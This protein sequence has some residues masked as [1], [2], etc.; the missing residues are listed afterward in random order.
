MDRFAIGRGD[1]LGLLAARD[2]HGKIV[3]RHEASIVSLFLPGGKAG[4]PD[5]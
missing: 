1:L 4:A 5:T 2:A 3:L